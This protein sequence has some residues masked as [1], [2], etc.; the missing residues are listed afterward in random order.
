MNQVK[1]KIIVGASIVFS[2]IM[3]VSAAEYFGTRILD[4]SFAIG[5]SNILDGDNDYAVLQYAGFSSLRCPGG[6][7]IDTNDS[8]KFTEGNETY[9]LQGWVMVD[10][11]TNNTGIYNVSEM[12]FNASE[13]NIGCSNCSDSTSFRVFTTTDWQNTST[14][15]THQGRCKINDNEHTICSFT[16]AN[17]YM[18]AFVAART[19]IDNSRPDPAIRWAKIIAP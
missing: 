14:V 13:L 17:E 8:C 16:I 15:W 2:L 12:Q 5:A 7:F 3:I 6:N 4:Q 1:K 19:N 18:E 11:M 10:L 9:Q